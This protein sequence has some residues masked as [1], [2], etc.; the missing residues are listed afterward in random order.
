MLTRNKHTTNHSN[1]SSHEAEIQK[2]IRID[3]RSW[4]DLQAVVP[5]VG[6]LEEA[7]HRV[8]YFVRNIKKP[9]TTNDTSLLYTL[10]APCQMHAQKCEF[11]CLTM[12][13]D[14]ATVHA[15]TVNFIIFLSLMSC[16][17]K[18]CQVL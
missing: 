1:E 15:E 17:E 6:I 3:R 9:V 11:L 4:V 5:V 7:V 8:E 18:I 16:S 10:Q 14:I 12:V 2:V 13:P